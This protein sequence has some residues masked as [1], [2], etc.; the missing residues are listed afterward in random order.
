MKAGDSKG[1]FEAVAVVD[2]ISYVK[3]LA[4][5]DKQ[6]KTIVINMSLTNMIRASDTSS[7]GKTARLTS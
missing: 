7:W 6:K 1:S 4:T 5:Q 3:D 2:A